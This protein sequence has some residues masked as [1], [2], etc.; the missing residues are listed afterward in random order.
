MEAKLKGIILTA[1]DL[2]EFQITE[3]PD[4]KRDVPVSTASPAACQPVEDTRLDAYTPEPQA[5]V[6]RY[7]VATRGDYR[8]VGST[9]TLAAFTPADAKQVMASVRAAVTACGEGYAGGALTFTQVST[10]DS[11]PVGDEAVSFQLVGRGTQPTWYTIVRQGS[12]LVRFASSTTSGQAG[13][14]PT[15]LVVQQVMKLTAAASGS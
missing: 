3:V 1:G 6:R 9:I 4:G 12:T 5:T 8:G 2:A 13:Q 15:P 7:A 11:V 10:V 14:V